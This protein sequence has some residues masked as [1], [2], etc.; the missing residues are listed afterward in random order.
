M[1]IFKHRISD[2]KGPFLSGPLPV[3]GD[4][5]NLY[6][7]NR[8]GPPTFH[9]R[10]D[11]VAIADSPG[12]TGPPDCTGPPQNTGVFKGADPPEKN[13]NNQHH[14]RT[15]I[16]NNITSKEENKMISMNTKRLLALAFTSCLAAMYSQTA[17]AVAGDVISNTAT[18]SYSVGG[19][20]QADEVDSV[21]F[22]EDRVIN[23]TVAEPAGTIGTVSAASTGTG[24]VTYEVT[25]NSNAVL[26]FSLTV[27]QA[28]VDNFDVLGP[29]SFFLEDGTTPGYQA[30]EDTVGVTFLD[31]VAIGGSVIVHVVGT[32]PAQADGDVAI[33]TLV[34]QAAESAGAP[35]ADI[36]N[37]DNGNISPGG[38]ASDTADNAGAMDTVF[39]D[40]AGTFDSTGAADSARNG[41]HSADDSF[42]IVAAQLTVTK[43]S[44][45]LWDPVNE[46]S[47][48]KSLPGGYVQYTIAVANNAAATGSADLTT[49]VDDLPVTLDLDPDLI[50]GVGATPAPTNAVGDGVRIQVLGSTRAVTDIFCTG[51]ADP[52]GCSYS[53]GPG[54]IISVD[55][56]TELVVDAVNGY[57]AG[58][59]KPGETV[60]VTFNVIVQ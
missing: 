30:T 29:F 15:G 7:K 60:N 40:A 56:A 37:D 47:N 20:A 4:H 18:M 33:V 22:T 53:V 23:F 27:V 57:T 28:A 10:G 5:K 31:D 48:P 17:S 11:S 41:Q 26:D 55:L 9:R 35:G 12:G 1:N 39:N 51:A 46:D 24:G 19:V 44:S 38:T 43:T 58:E 45:A 16:N 52:D 14:S 54:G 50:D 32:M 42:T 2:G 21:N 25:N 36:T 34:A 8:D 6:G 59:L 49:L 3:F 13:V